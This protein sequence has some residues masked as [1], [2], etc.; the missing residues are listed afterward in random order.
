MIYLNLISILHHH[1]CTSIV[2]AVYDDENDQKGEWIARHGFEI[3]ILPFGSQGFEEAMQMGSETYHH[4]KAVI[5]GKYGAHGCNVGE[6]GG[7]AL[8]I[9]RHVVGD[10]L[11]MSNSKHVERAIEEHACNALLLKVNQI[12]SVT[13]AIEVVKMEKDGNWGVVISQR[14]G[15]TDDSFLADLSV[16]L[17][18]SQIKAGA[19]CRGERLAK[20]NQLI[21]IE[22]EIGDQAR[23]QM[24]KHIKGRRARRKAVHQKRKKSSLPIVL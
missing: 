19:S 13:E 5:A 3:M 4:L 23:I 17:G 11:L 24:I 21:R 9:T 20:Y 22:E 7:L 8:D 2:M 12:G 16:G 14:S 18:T 6:D 15:E 1:H 10:D